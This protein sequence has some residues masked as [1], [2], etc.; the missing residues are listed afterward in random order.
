MCR[1]EGESQ[2]VYKL[3]WSKEGIL[4][5]SRHLTHDCYLRCGVFHHAQLDLRILHNP[6]VKKFLPDLISCRARRFAID[7]DQSEDGYDDVAIRIDAK[8]SCE[9]GVIQHVQTDEEPRRQLEFREVFRH[10]AQRS[11]R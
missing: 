2:Y 6:I 1:S 8:T 4:S 11:G 10:H 9:I 7:M 5:R 3:S